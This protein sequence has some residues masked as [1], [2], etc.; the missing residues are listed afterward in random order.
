MMGGSGTGVTTLGLSVATRLKCACLDTE[1]FYW[2]PTTPPYREKRPVE[3]RIILIREK[4]ESVQSSGCVL[5]GSLDGWGDPLIP[6]FDAVVFLAAPVHVRI[7]RLRWREKERF[8]TEALAP[9]GAIHDQHEAF[10]EWA[11][12]YD[13]GTMPG[14]SLPRHEQWLKRL[15]CPVRRLDGTKTIDELVQSV[16]RFLNGETA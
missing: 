5:S 11:A 3:D 6:L 2:L 7:E 10:M 8:G 14:R 9:G 4:L 15:P 13:A 12:A 1:D 16:C